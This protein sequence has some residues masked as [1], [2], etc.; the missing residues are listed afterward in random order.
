MGK[1]Q[2]T[3]IIFSSTNLTVADLFLRL[4]KTL[5]QNIFRHQNSYCGDSTLLSSIHGN[6]ST[7]HIQEN[8]VTRP[9]WWWRP[10]RYS[11]YFL[12]CSNAQHVCNQELPWKS[13]KLTAFML[14]VRGKSYLVKNKKNKILKHKLYAVL[15]S[16]LLH[17]TIQA[18]I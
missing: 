12:F 8:K 18:Q 10:I 15:S 16:P 17:S 2:L 3:A 11:C 4:I 13:W 1:M 9:C 6:F 7:Y 14:S 5:S